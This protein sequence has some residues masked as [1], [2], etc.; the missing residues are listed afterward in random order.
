MSIA[1]ARSSGVNII[2]VVYILVRNSCIS[3]KQFSEFTA[4]HA[5]ESRLDDLGHVPGATY[6]AL[7]ASVQGAS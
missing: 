2:S 1:A 3:S 6:A 7:W 4:T 5:N